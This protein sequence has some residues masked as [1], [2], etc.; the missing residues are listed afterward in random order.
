MI[1]PMRM[2]SAWIPRHVRSIA[3]AGLLLGSTLFGVVPARAGT[4]TRPYYFLAR[5]R[6]L[7]EAQM[8]SS[9]WQNI[10]LVSAVHYLKLGL[11]KGG[12][13]SGYA[14]AI[15]TLEAFERIPITSET[16]TQMTDSHRD[17]SMLNIFFDVGTA[18]AKILL[19]DAPSGSLFRQA[20]ISY[21]DE[22]AGIHNGVNLRLLKDAVVDLR[23]ESSDEGPRAVLFIA[24]IAD[25]T[26]LEGAS[27]ATIDTSSANLSNPYRQDID[28]LNALFETQR[29]NGPGD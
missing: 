1:T 28:Y 22:P 10:P 16:T 29:L 15:T 25:L 5:T 23:R 19:D 3:I 20:R 11:A 17:W 12:D 6:W 24:A 8:V 18:Q 21:G 13:T 4:T 7:S 26:N 27:A 14:H 9:A 2:S